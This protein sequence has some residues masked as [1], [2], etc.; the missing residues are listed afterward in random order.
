[1]ANKLLFGLMLLMAAGLASAADVTYTA[2]NGFVL[3][4]SKTGIDGASVNVLCLDNSNSFSTTSAPNG[5]YAGGFDCPMNG[6]VS[7]NATKGNASAT[8]T[9]PVK[10]INTLNFGQATLDLGLAFVNVEI[11]EFPTAAVPA[12]LSMLSFGL[13][14][15][16]RK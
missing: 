16:R 8:A 3:D 6:T 5:Y 9:G 10:F 13:V 2:V 7:V 15:Y 14:R 1:M 4:P 12:L 11:P